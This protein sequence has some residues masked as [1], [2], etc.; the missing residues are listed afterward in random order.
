MRQ[1]AEKSVNSATVVAD[2]Y[3][4]YPL[5]NV[6]CTAYSLH[7]AKTKKKRGLDRKQEMINLRRDGLSLAAIAHRFD[8]SKTRVA[9]I[10]SDVEL[11]RV[12]VP[13]ESV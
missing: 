9:Q 8:I 10:L 4:R 6:Q 1:G 13:E 2:K 7:V 11:K 3:F 5:D 12:Y